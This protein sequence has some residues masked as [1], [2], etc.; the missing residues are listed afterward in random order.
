MLT[1]ANFAYRDNFDAQFIFPVK[2]TSFWTSQNTVALRYVRTNLS[3]SPVTFTPRK[4]NIDL[5]TIHTLTLPG[6]VRLE[7]SAYYVSPSLAVINIFRTYLT[8]DAGLKNTVLAK[9]LD[10]H[11]A[12]TALFNT[13]HY[14]SYS[15]YEGAN[16][17]YNHV[18]DNRRVNLSP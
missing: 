11:L 2:I 6:D 13:I 17:S 9:K 8:V 3:Q 5:S 14:W 1:I 10:V 12:G 16:T 18:G 7:L 15:I 4:A